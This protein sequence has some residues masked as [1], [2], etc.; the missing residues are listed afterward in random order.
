[1]DHMARIGCEMVGGSVVKLSR[2]AQFRTP[3]AAG[4]LHAFANTNTNTEQDTVPPSFC[5]I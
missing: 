5:I 4:A 1:M 3:P 2:S